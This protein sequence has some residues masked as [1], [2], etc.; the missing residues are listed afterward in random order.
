MKPAMSSLVA[1]YVLMTSDE[2]AHEESQQASRV[3]EHQK[4]LS[5]AQQ[6]LSAIAKARK[7]INRKQKGNCHGR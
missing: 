3:Y 6:A 4:R 1:L 2:L 7:V 5:T